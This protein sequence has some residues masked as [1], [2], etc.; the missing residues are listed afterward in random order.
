MKLTIVDVFGERRYEGNQLA[1]VEDAGELDADAM[2]TIAREMNFSETTFVTSMSADSADVRIFTPAEELPFAGH[3][4]LGTAWVLG[5]DRAR[6]MLRLAGGDVDVKFLDGLVWM[7]PPPAELRS[8]IDA[9][10]AAELVGLPPDEL[11][12]DWAP[13][14][15]YS[16]AEYCL[17]PLQS[18]RALE[19]IAPDLAVVR[20]QSQGGALFSV[21][22]EA[23]S[24]DADFAVRMHFFDGVG[25]RE[26][27]ATGSANTA[28]ALYLREAG[29][30][31][32]FIV[33]QGFEVGRPSRLYLDV[34][35]PIRVGG[36]VQLVAEGRL[37][38]D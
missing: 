28:F 27:P 12:G 18:R 14:R 35:E 26:D 2:Q 37:N 1:V 24:E 33:E 8:E 38:R 9:A 11:D 31:G 15:V 6:F 25:L 19:S 36:R 30:N 32:R 13:R 5:R 17:V 3:P 23:Y 21:C 7:V 20:A 10:A 16:G 4:T 34:G 29:L 22:R